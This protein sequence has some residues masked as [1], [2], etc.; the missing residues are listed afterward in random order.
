M[1]GKKT[2]KQNLVERYF[3]VIVLLITAIALWKPTGFI[4]MK[5]HI[6]KLLGIIMFGMGVSLTF[7]DFKKLKTDKHEKD[8]VIKYYTKVVVDNLQMLDSRQEAKSE[9]A[10]QG[11]PSFDDKDI[12]F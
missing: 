5:P 10:P 3:I 1:N 6:P 8:G 9:S 2:V 12:P 11:D 4:W 7:S